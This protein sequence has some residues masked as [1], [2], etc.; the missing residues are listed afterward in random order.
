MVSDHGRKER[1]QLWVLEEKTDKQVALGSHRVSASWPNHKNI[2]WWARTSLS[3]RRIQK[4]FSPHSEIFEGD[5]Y[6]VGKP[7]S[8]ITMWWMQYKGRCSQRRATSD[9]CQVTG[10]ECQEESKKCRGLSVEEKS[11]FVFRSILDTWHFLLE[12]QK[13]TK[14]WKRWNSS[15][16]H[17]P[18]C[19]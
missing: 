15:C 16:W 1:R 14:P 2:L 12:E 13:E 4:V 18:R 17:A 19:W 5:D 9:E 8:R 6:T 7:P 3:L 10:V 11:L